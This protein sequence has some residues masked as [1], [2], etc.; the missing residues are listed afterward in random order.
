MS[1]EYQSLYGEMVNRLMILKKHYS[2]ITDDWLRA[3]NLPNTREVD[4]MQQRL[5]QLRRENIQLKKE[6]GDI[7]T[8]VERLTSR[9]SATPTA[10]LARADEPAP[11]AARKKVVKPSPAR[12]NTRKAAKPAVRKAAVKKA[13]VK[14]AARKKSAVTKARTGA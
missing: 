11:R 6:L 3:L 10:T 9:L 12:P 4:T 1:D 13:A 14:K 5:Q 7:R 2:E 8:L